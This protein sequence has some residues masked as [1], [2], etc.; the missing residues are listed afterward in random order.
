M[1]GGEGEERRQNQTF[2]VDD[3][4]TE[5]RITFVENQIQNSFRSNPTTF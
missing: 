2:W 5:G 1:R 4:N 3:K